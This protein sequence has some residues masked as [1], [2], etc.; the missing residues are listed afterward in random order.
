MQDRFE[1]FMKET[2][3]I[4]RTVQQIKAAEMTGLGL[5]GMHV[6][7]LYFLY[8]HTEGLTAVQLCELCG[9]DKAS[10]SRTIAALKEKGYVTEEQAGLPKKYRSVITLTDS[11]KDLGKIEGEKIVKAINAGG[12]GL[13]D[14]GRT[15]FYSGLSLI[16]KNLKNYF[17]ELKNNPV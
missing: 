10:V 5:K 12:E 2:T 8:K 1:V 3:A 15:G 6:M 16:A 17:A 4:Y 14:D 11:G 7:C 13:D 9:E